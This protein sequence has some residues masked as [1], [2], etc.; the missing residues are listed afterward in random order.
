MLALGAHADDIEIGCGG[1][2][3]QLIREGVG[4]RSVCWVVLSG[5][6]RRA[7]EA[8]AS[9][10]ALLD[11]VPETADPPA[12]FRDGFLPYDGARGQGV[13]RGAQARLRARLILTHQRHDLHQDHRL[14]CELTW[15]T[16]RDHLILEYEVPKYDGDLG[17]PERVRARSTTRSAGARST[18]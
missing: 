14:A 2:I 12:R 7:E 1:T 17:A 11:G 18:S 4:R 10:E 6:E 16:F 9:A 15:N 8:R 5:E 3:L 13:L